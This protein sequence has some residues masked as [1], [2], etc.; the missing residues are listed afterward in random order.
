[1]KSTHKAFAANWQ[2]ETAKVLGMAISGLGLIF[3]A[4]ILIQEGSEGIGG[5]V[6]LMFLFALP[7]SFAGFGFYLTDARE[8]LADNALFPGAL[9]S[10]V[11]TSFAFLKSESP[12]FGA[13]SFAV[14]AFFIPFFINGL[15]HLATKGLDYGRQSRSLVYLLLSIAAA[16]STGLL[17]FVVAG[18]YLARFS[19]LVF[20]VFAFLIGITV[21][22]HFGMGK[23]KPA[24]ILFTWTGVGNLLFAS[25]FSIALGTFFFP[26]GILLAQCGMVIMKRDNSMAQA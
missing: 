10:V 24:V 4:P 21:H 13:W 23:Q 9:L 25:T 2:R 11:M 5:P 22:S 6:S 16:I 18:A 12:V 19:L 8:A 17:L 26:L 20:A 14:Y 3:L 1:M 7:L 15:S